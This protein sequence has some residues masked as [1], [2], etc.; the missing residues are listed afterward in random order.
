[1]VR[2]CYVRFHLDQIERMQLLNLASCLLL[3]VIEVVFV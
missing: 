3:T 2:I 1:M